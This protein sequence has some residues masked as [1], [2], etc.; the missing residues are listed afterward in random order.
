MV[1]YGMLPEDAIVCSWH[2][3]EVLCMLKMLMLIIKGR[4]C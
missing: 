3:Q 4:Q 2:L 1:S